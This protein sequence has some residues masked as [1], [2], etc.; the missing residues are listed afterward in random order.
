LVLM[1]SIMFLM[2]LSSMESFASDDS[3]MRSSSSNLS[4]NEGELATGTGAGKVNVQDIMMTK[5]TATGTGAGK[6]NVQDI[7]MTKT[8]ATGTGA[9]KVNVQDIMMTKREAKEAL[10]K[11]IEANNDE[12]RENREIFREAHGEHIKEVKMGL[13]TER[14]ATFK[15]FMVTKRTAMEELRKKMKD[16]SPEERAELIEEMKILAES[17]YEGAQELV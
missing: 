14:K 7:M 3:D 13:T 15:E 8:T 10:K 2:S 5:T 9:G 1:L 11:E 12:A 16:A 6:V 4:D 17:F